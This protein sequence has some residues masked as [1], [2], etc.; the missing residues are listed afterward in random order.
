MRSPRFSLADLLAL[1]GN[2]CATDFHSPPQ[3]WPRVA[4]EDFS[5]VAMI[6]F[7]AVTSSSW[8]LESRLDT[9][10][11]IRRAAVRPLPFR[12]G[13]QLDSDLFLNSRHGSHRH[14][15]LFEQDDELWLRDL[16]STNGTSVNGLRLKGPCRV[17]DGDVIHFAD[18][19]FQIV[20]LPTENALQTTQVFSLLERE[21][22]EAQV[23]APGEFRAMLRDQAFRADFQPVVRLADS[24]TFGYEILG[25]GNL[26]GEAATPEELFYIAEQLGHEVALSNAFRARGLELARDLPADAPAPILFMNTHPAEIGDPAALLA[27]LG[28]LRRDH[29]D[30][31]LVLEIH[32]AAVADLS[33]LQTLRAGLDDLDIKIAFDDFGTG[34]ARLL[35]LAEVQPQY[36]KFDAAWVENLHLASPRRHEMISSLLRMVG[37]F[38]VVPIAECVEN[39]AEAAACQ[40][41]GFGLAQGNYFGP[42][43]PLSAAAD[44]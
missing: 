25:R 10:G 6:R 41:L 30:P 21:R 7:L 40:E 28:T 26:G 27:S 3:R 15:E 43:A 39:R 17:A 33:S 42:P 35:E 9:R 22:L 1:W 37:D 23:K 14:A 4:L 38:G 13:R 36:L 44:R 29:P 16:D 18:L 19:E 5:A 8:Y 24:E 34:Q 31:R 2:P 12:I 20:E 11:R 32:E